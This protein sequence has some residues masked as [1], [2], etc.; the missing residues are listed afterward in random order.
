MIDECIQFD[1]LNFRLLVLPHFL[2][3][4]T[5]RDTRIEPVAAT[6][7]TIMQY[8]SIMYVNKH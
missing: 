5:Y 6:R 1:N 4:M 8:L 7:F 2:T 3:V